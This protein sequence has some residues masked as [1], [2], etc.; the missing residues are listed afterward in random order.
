MSHQLPLRFLITLAAAAAIAAQG[1]A[2]RPIK[3]SQAGEVVL[4]YNSTHG[5]LIQHRPPEGAIGCHELKP[6]VVRLTG[7]DLQVA[8]QPG[9][10]S[11]RSSFGGSY[12][13]GEKPAQKQ[14]K[15][16][17][18]VED[19]W[20][21]GY[22]SSLPQTVKHE[23]ALALL[24]QRSVSDI[25]GKL[26]PVLTHGSAKVY[27]DSSVTYTVRTSDLYPFTSIDK[28]TASKDGKVSTR[29]GVS[30][31]TEIQGRYVAAEFYLLKFD[32]CGVPQTEIRYQLQGLRDSV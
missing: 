14:V 11:V 3:P 13:V 1:P 21:P 25:T 8:W 12:P 19:R 10:I 24:G 17:R 29:L 30:R 23:F 4:N 22:D 31:W 6:K 20:R 15:K 16:V 32:K 28:E 2:N 9:Q 27:R 18:V 26:T 5:F 7:M